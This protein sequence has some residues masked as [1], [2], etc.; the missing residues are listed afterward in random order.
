MQV[1]G[2]CRFS[3]P[4]IGGFRLSH[5]TIEEHR[6]FLYAPD[7]MEERFRLFE[8]VTLSGF[9]VQT[10]ERFELLVI[11][12]TC[13]PQPYSD[14]LRDLVAGIK[15]VRII[16]KDPADHKQVMRET[17]NTARTDPHKPCLQFRHDDD[18]AVSV[19]FIEKLRSATRENAG[20]MQQSESV[21]IDYN[22]GYVARCNKHQIHV[23]QVYRTLLGVG[24]G[25]YIQG[26]SKRTIFDRLHNRLARFMPVVSYPD[27]P[28]WMRMLHGFN[29]SDHARK[30]TRELLPLNPEQA[31]EL[32]TRFAI[33]P[34]EFETTPVRV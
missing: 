21:A 9:R 20:L 18:D 28:M 12:E 24:L 26:G 31:E 2:L 17:L 19:D 15:Q 8:T 11:T 32:R 30:D 10:D 6:Q 7:R 5:K 16:E 27:A 1:I 29:D 14:R 33:D 13:L 23:A 3:Y 25:M 34:K 22:H 4:A